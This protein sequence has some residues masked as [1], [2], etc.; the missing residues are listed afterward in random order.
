[1]AQCVI[2]LST[3]LAGGRPLVAN[4]TSDSITYLIGGYPADVSLDASS[5]PGFMLMTATE[6]QQTH[7]AVPSDSEVYSA[8][9]AIFAAGLGA[10]GLI[11][12]TKRVLALFNAGRSE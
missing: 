5:C 11:W 4:G 8:C 9:L 1:M 2:L 12:G 10:M 7:S 3:P 6:F